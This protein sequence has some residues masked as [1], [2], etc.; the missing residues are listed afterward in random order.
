MGFVDCELDATETHDLD[1]DLVRISVSRLKRTNFYNNVF[2]KVVKMVCNYLC[3][4]AF[5]RNILAS[6]VIS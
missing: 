4:K 5:A 3:I 1:L 2:I 6:Q